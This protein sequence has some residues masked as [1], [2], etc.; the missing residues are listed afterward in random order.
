MNDL[1]IGLVGAV[2]ATNQPAAVSN[3]V[4][5]HVG[6]SINVATNSDPSEIQLQKIMADDDTARGEIDKWIRDNEAFK[7]QG[8]GESDAD[9]NRR[10]MA[11][12]NIIRTNYMDFTRQY[13]NNPHGYLA[14][15]SF[16]NEIGEEEA[17]AQQY[18]RSREIDPKNPAVWN[19]LAN[20]Y[21]EFSPVTNAFAYYTKAIQLDPNEAIYYENFA[22][23]VYLYRKDAREFYHIN[24]QQVFDKAMGLYAQAMQHAPDDFRLASVCAESYYGIK[25]FRT[26]DA[27]AAWTNALHVAH[28]DLERESVYIHLAR[29]KMLF[30]Y[31]DE[32]RTQL[33]A[34]TNS[35]LAATKDRVSRAITQREHDATNPPPAEVSTNA[36]TIS[37]NA[38]AKG[39]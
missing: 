16:L 8:A 38:P 5:Q 31:Y 36:V 27:L 11:R 28:D 10:I 7:K 19:N 14:Y 15:G 37:T 26:N 34:V 12:L 30:G 21:G 35:V 4:Q 32:A 29:M 23:T 6:I 1:L 3:L 25:P 24:E 17:G 39:P 9:L 13:S 18:E 20:Y 2:L 22:T 33:T